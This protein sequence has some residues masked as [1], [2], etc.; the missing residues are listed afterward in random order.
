MPH[1]A[2]NNSRINTDGWYYVEYS[3]GRYGWVSSSFTKRI[4]TSDLSFTKLAD[5]KIT[6]PK[7]KQISTQTNTKELLEL[8]SSVSF[9]L[10]EI[11]KIKIEKNEAKKDKILSLN[12]VNKVEV[13]TTFDPVWTPDMMTNYAREKLGFG[14]DKEVSSSTPERDWE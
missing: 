1:V 10:A 3:K 4:L 7:K 13:T 2:Y 12:K 11:E 5:T 9:L 14:E 8:R 6:N